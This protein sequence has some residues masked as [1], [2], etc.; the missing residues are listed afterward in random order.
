M[1]PTITQLNDDFRLIDWPAVTYIEATGDKP[2]CVDKGG[3]H[4]GKE[5][6]GVAVPFPTRNHGELHKRFGIGEDEDGNV[7]A[8][9]KGAMITSDRRA[10]EFLVAARI[11]Q[12]V[13]YKGRRYTIRQEPNQNI[14]LDLVD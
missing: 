7:F 12:T 14:A 5:V 6:P 1:T 13:I 11:G 9:G 2:L 4:L 10:K 3:R 8:Y